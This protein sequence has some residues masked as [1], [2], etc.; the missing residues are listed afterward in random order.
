MTLGTTHLRELTSK[1][2]AGGG[3]IL[4][5]QTAFFGDVILLTPLLRAI[6]KAFPASSITA[7]TIPETASLLRE[8]VDETITFDKRDRNQKS[9]NWNSLV[10]QIRS[11]RFD[12]ALVPHRSLRSGITAWKGGIS[13]RIGFDRSAGSWFH[14]LKVPYPFGLY[15]GSRNLELLRSLAEVTDDGLPALHPPPEDTRLVDALL[16][17]LDLQHRKFVVIAPASVWLTKRWPSRFYRSL[18]QNLAD[19]YQLPTVSVGSVADAD[20]CSNTVVRPEYNLAGRLTLLQ[21]CALMTRARLVVSG[22][23]APAHLATAAGVNQLIIF[24]STIPR[25]GF[26]PPVGRARTMGRDLWCRP[27]TD[28]GRNLCP[29]PAGMKCLN[30]IHPD[31]VLTRIEDWVTT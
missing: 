22:D 15:E 21:T 29:N 7:L 13:F 8:W 12:L 16:E 27:C 1:L 31:E 9:A 5:I 24:G 10:A 18:S 30:G 25:F 20:Q 2:E 23:S 4:V 11:E 3:K 17:S 28:H 19:R 6:K 26:A 14:S